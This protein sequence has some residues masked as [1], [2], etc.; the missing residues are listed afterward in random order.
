MTTLTLSTQADARGI[1]SSLEKVL[2]KRLI[3]PSK[4]PQKNWQAVAE[5]DAKNHLK[6]AQA[7]PKTRIV[8]RYT[9]QQQA[10]KEVRFGL[11]PHTH[12][13]TG[14]HHG[15]PYSKARIKQRYGIENTKSVEVKETI[16][17][18]AGHPVLHNKVPGGEAGVGEI[19][20]PKSLPKQSIIK[21]TPAPH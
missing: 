12:M 7:L 14:V 13:T 3:K 18:P 2:A 19:T 1:G 20:S 21:I 5:K 16:R 11:R 4:L 15:H 17:I 6:P 9:S 10:Q 8:E